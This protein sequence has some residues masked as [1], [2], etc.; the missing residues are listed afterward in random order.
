MK[1]PNVTVLAIDDSQDILFAISAICELEGW[2][3]ICT[4]DAYEAI[5]VVKQR[6]PDIVLVDYHMPRMD[7][8]EVVRNI[9]A[10]DAEIPILVLTIE[11]SRQVAEAFFEAGADDFALKPIKPVDLISRIRLHLRVAGMA[12]QRGAEKPETSHTAEE[13]GKGITPATLSIICD[14][15][16]KQTEAM[17]LNDISAGCGIAYQTAYR[18]L[19]YLVGEGSVNVYSE[20]GKQG[21]PKQKYILK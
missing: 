13:Y 12:P 3:T 14:F 15:M 6:K 16:N 20:Y 2:E 4:S 17:T 18:Y 11:S 9:R 1:Q 10:V 5:N 8:I 19:T 7:G 21:R